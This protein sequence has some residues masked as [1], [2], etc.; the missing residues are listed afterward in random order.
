MRIITNLDALDFDQEVVRVFQR[1]DN[2]ELIAQ[3]LHDAFGTL[4]EAF[5]EYTTDPETYLYGDVDEERFMIGA[6]N[7]DQLMNAAKLWNQEIREKFVAALKGLG[8]AGITAETLPIDNDKTYA[9]AC[10]AR[11]LDNCWWC[12]A[13]H[14]TYLPN[15]I[16]YPYFQCSLDEKTLQDI[17]NRPEQYMI[18]EVFVK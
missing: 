18:V 15:S 9:M 6:Q 8:G 2:P 14:A 16:G 3:M 12:Y 13:E 5:L 4:S 1:K 11:E 7:P 17:I 10:A